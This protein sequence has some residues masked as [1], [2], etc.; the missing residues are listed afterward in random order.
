MNERADDEQF[1]IRLMQACP[2]LRKVILLS[3]SENLMEVYCKQSIQVNSVDDLYSAI[4]EQ[5]SNL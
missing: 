3:L 4:E 1:S 2:E 5:F